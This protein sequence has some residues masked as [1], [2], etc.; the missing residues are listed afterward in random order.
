MR[1]MYEGM[2]DEWL[3]YAV[4]EEE[5]LLDYW[6]VDERDGGGEL[7]RRDVCAS[8]EGMGIVVQ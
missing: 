5:G 1:G 7:G 6:L 4:L 3:V 8:G 2:L